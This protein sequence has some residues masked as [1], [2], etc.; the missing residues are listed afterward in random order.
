MGLS[1]NPR[2]LMDREFTRKNNRDI[3]VI[4]ISKYPSKNKKIVQLFPKTKNWGIFEKE[5]C[6]IENGVDLDDL[7]KMTP[8]EKVDLFNNDEIT[9]I[10]SKTERKLDKLKT[11][12]DNKN[13]D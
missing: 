9:L 2:F 10:K 3:D 12:D 8:D 11:D 5:E 7:N 13:K 1:F 4:D 6:K